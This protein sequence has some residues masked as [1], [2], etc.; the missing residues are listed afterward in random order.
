MRS[1]VPQILPPPPPFP[2]TSTSTK[3][4]AST[5][6]KK[7]HKKSTDEQPRVEVPDELGKLI[8]RDM[9]L[10]ERDGWEA[11]VK[12]RRGRG[13]LT[14]MRN[15]DH[16]ARHLLRRYQSRGV[17]VVLHHDN[18]NSCQIESALARGPHA[19]AN[20]HQEFL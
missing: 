14:D 17:P 5:C 3:G 6:P 13:D 19:S 11:F 15:V 8:A 1:D 16:P 18:W 2:S 20:L 7:V 10:V 12:E 9:A 4:L